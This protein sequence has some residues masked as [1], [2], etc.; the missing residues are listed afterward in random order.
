MSHTPRRLRS[1]EW[2]D[3]PAHADM[4]A[5]YVERFMNYGIT[6]EE[7]RSMEGASK[8]A[9]E[10]VGMVEPDV[11]VYGCTSGSF[12][13]GPE[14]MRPSLAVDLEARRPHELNWLT[15]TVVTLAERLE[16]PWSIA[17]LPDSRLLI[18]ERPGRLRIFANGSLSRTAVSGV[19]EVYASGQGGLLDVCLHPN[20]A[21]NK[22]IYL[23][24]ADGAG[25]EVATTV[26]RAE[27]TE[28]GLRNVS[29]IFRG[30]PVAG[31][32]HF[33]SR[34]VFDRA[35]EQI[36][37]YRKIHLFDIVTPDGMAYK[38]SASIKPGDE[39]VTYD[40]DGV[41]VVTRHNGVERQRAKASDMVFP[42]PMLLAYVSRYIT[43][44]AGDLLL[45]GTPAG[46][47][48]GL[49]PP[50]YIA[51]GDVIRIEIDGVGR[52]ENRFV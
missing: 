46:V 10:E 44:E 3:D 24:Y 17:F 31:G 21:Q 29:V 15:G 33:G 8:V 16:Y 11:V 27:W 49:N 36:A 37:R 19:P 25:S 38:E 1:Q 9:A 32:L 20:F 26:A 23:S 7:L 6:P 18:T 45:T 48:M 40:L 41:T 34:I 50:R 4:T 51:S 47:G 28:G 13:E 30:S 5:L 39:V 12:F 35:G 52:I 2:F 22:L 14:H 43:L 42:I